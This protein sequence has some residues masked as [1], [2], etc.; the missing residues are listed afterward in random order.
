MTILAQQLTLHAPR[1]SLWLGTPAKVCLDGLA[2]ETPVQS[3]LQ[4]NGS[5]TIQFFSE[6]PKR[7]GVV[8]KF[9]FAPSP[10][11]TAHSK[12]KPEI[13]A[14]TEWGSILQPDDSIAV[15]KIDRSSLGQV[16]ELEN[17]FSEEE[18]KRLITVS[19]RIG[20]GT[21]NF[22]K[23]YRGNLR[24][25]VTDRSLTARCWNRIKDL[26]P[27]TVEYNKCTWEAFGLNE[28]WRLARYSPGDVFQRHC[29]ACYFASSTEQS[30]FTVNVYMNGGF[31]GGRT[32]FYG[33]PKK[34]QCTGTVRD[35]EVVYACVPKPGMAL[36]FRQ[37]QGAYLLH[38]GEKL[39]SGRKYL[40][41]T[42]VMYRKVPEHAAPR[43][44]RWW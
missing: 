27:K 2:E 43:S 1:L 24:L 9:P 14:D 44:K 36:V 22:P 20:Y 34:R 40:F 6:D 11:S 28:R 26:V 5:I 29:D 17:L 42:D 41:R 25:M 10:T 32:R 16:F 15:R 31:E 3:L 18:C 35:T 37:P 7:N 23:N 13:Q 8:E 30:M 21:T 33:D 39:G 19:E 4:N 38:D 12:I